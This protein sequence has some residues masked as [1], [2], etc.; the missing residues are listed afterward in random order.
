MDNMKYDETTPVI[1][2]AAIISKE[3]RLRDPLG[4]RLFLGDISSL[5]YPRYDSC[6]F[7]KKSLSFRTPAGRPVRGR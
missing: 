1:Q 3:V 2:N 6:A 5:R 4:E 7:L